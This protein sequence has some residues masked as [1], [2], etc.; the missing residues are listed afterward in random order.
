[1][2][3]VIAGC[4]E[5]DGAVERCY[6][7]GGEPEF[8]TLYAYTP[9]AEALAD[10]A[11][12]VEALEVWVL[13]NGVDLLRGIRSDLLC[14]LDAHK[15]LFLPAAKLPT[16]TIDEPPQTPFLHKEWGHYFKELTCQ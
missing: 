9:R 13:M 4:V 10:F 2:H 5:S 15:V 6:D 7:V 11:T 14:L 3:Y 8:W 12:E 1:M 16:V